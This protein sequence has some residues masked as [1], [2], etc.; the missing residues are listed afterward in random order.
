MHL[1]DKEKKDVKKVGRQL[2]GTLKQEKLVLDWRK[3]QQS[4]AQVRL[5]VEQLLDRLAPKY[6]RQVFADK[7]NLVYRHIY[8]SYYG[9]NRSVYTL[10]Y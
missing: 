10:A 7:C 6:T 2:L 8:D 4:R 1:T 5:T 9:E 3:R